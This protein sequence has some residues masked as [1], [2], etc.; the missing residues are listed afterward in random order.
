M[1]H[2]ADSDPKD[3]DQHSPQTTT[4]QMPLP[5]H[6]STHSLDQQVHLMMVVQHT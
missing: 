3:D 1:I 6:C 2:I 5:H 4:P